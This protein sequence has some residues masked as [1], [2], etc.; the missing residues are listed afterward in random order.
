LTL[1]LAIPAKE[2]IVFASDGQ[3]TIGNVRTHG[4]KLYQLNK[5]CAW[6]GSGE[7]ALIQRVREHI[8]QLPP[9]PL[10]EIRDTLAV[11]IRKSVVELLELDFRTNFFRE[12][13][14][15]LLDLHPA[16]F[17]FVEH[18]SQP[19]ILHVT[20]SGTPEW[21]IDDRPFATGNGDGF[22]YAL[23]QKYQGRPMELDQA[24]V[25]AVK[26]IQEVIEVGAYGLGPPI[27]LWKVTQNGIKAHSDSEIAALEDVAKSVREVE[28]DAVLK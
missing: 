25:L 11:E 8:T 17:V 22:A 10:E 24:S 15:T 16:D 9:S 12:A 5:N 7:V 2:G 28:I 26:V 18:I 21:W 6:A 1:V 23:L 3:V 14:G 19:R 4:E 13:P 20:H 27:A